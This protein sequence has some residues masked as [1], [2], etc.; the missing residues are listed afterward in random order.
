MRACTERNAIDNK[1]REPYALAS[2]AARTID[3]HAKRSAPQALASGVARKNLTPLDRPPTDPRLAPAAHRVAAV[4]G[5][6]LGFTLV[7]LLV[8]IMLIGILASFVLVALAG[9]TQTAKEDRT[10]AQIAKIHELIME[11]WEDY[12]YRRVPPTVVTRKAMQTAT[13]ATSLSG[14]A[15]SCEQLAALRELMRM[16]MPTFSSDVAQP[17]Q[18]IVGSAVVKGNNLPFQPARWRAYRN[19]AEFAFAQTGINWL[20]PETHSSGSAEYVAATSNQ[21]AEC[22]YLVL[23]QMRTADTSALEFF[24]DNEIGD[25]DGDGMKEILDAWGNPIGWMLWAPGHISP[26]QVPLAEKLEQ[27]D[28]FD[29]SQVGSGYTNFSDEAYT[30]QLGSD[31]TYQGNFSQLPRTLYPLIYS[32]GPDGKLGIV[33]RTDGDGNGVIDQNWAAVKNDPYSRNPGHQMY[34]LGAPSVANPEAG[35]DDITNHTLALAR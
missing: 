33:V 32:S 23:S 5:A 21:Q 14:E 2:G 22:L 9:A 6:P 1:R 25:V 12:Q 8:V 15:F 26:L 16:E 13:V 19:R 24:K 18:K 31:L 11:H 29:I 34:A 35:Q 27:H 3:F 10:R 4:A 17:A 30:V 28:L 7:E 20:N